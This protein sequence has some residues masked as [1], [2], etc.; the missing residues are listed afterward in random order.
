MCPVWFC[1]TGTELDEI[2]P[3]RQSQSA[4]EKVGGCFRG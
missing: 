1:G 3:G 2:G 4:R